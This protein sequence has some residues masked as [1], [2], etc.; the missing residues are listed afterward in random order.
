[1]EKSFKTGHHHENTELRRRQ[2][3]AAA[4]RLIVRHGS[5]HVTVRKMAD[6]IGVSEGAIYRHFR[7]KREILSFLIDDVGATLMAEVQ[8]SSGSLNPL[9]TLEAIVRSHVS[10]I[11]QRKGVSFL[12][13]AEIISLGDRKLNKQAYE[14]ISRYISLVRDLL[15]EGIKTGIVRPDIDPD[16]A[17]TLFFSMIQGMVNI[18]A[19][20]RHSFDLQQK[21][22]SLWSVFRGTLINNREPAA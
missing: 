4:R 21:Y 6:E 5:E 13:I 22:L 1:M 11:E 2:I 14:I 16:A 18:W 12:V 19:L 15:S 10:S 8:A 7:S 17:A 3:V 20:S 9:E